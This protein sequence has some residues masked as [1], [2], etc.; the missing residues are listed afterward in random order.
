MRSKILYDG[1]VALL[2]GSPRNGG[3]RRIA[4]ILLVV[5]WVGRTF[6]LVI[7]RAQL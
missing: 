6:L 7:V 2:E 3:G 1:H 4:E 5:A